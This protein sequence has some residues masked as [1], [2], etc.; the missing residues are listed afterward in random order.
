[1][2][3]RWTK[4]AADNLVSIVDF[5]AEDKPDAASA[6]ARKI[7][8]SMKNAA[9]FP[10]S[11]RIVP[12]FGIM[13]IREKLVGNFRVVYRIAPKCI[14]VLAVVESHRLLEKRIDV[15]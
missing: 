1:M 6:L 13:E 2:K 12:E 4:N 9:C 3:V 15:S 7:Q 14:E 11:G 10:K 8:A 5:I